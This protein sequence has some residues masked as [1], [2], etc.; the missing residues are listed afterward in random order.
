M[1]LSVKD[2]KIDDED[3]VMDQEQENEMIQEEQPQG[4]GN[5]GDKETVP[6]KLATPGDQDQQV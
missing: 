4:Q 6:E 3:Q 2:E 5:Q 1:P